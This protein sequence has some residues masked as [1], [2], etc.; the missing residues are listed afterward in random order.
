MPFSFLLL[1]SVPLCNSDPRSWTGSTHSS[2]HQ[3]LLRAGGKCRQWATLC[4][5]VKGVQLLPHRQPWS[6]W[7]AWNPT[8]S[9][10]RKLHGCSNRPVK[11]W[12]DKSWKGLMSVCL[13]DLNR[14]R[15]YCSP[16]NLSISTRG[17]RTNVTC[18]VVYFIFYFW[19]FYFLL[20]LLSSP[21]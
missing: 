9:F 17:F 12:E 14:T 10:N 2:P 13:A 8:G 20:T 16:H 15:S 4:I 7:A 3:F 11:R 1:A 19:G 18:S 6:P 21:F 5:A